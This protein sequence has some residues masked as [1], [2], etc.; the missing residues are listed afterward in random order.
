MNEVLELLL[1]L[2]EIDDRI[3]ALEDEVKH[4]PD[5]RKKLLDELETLRR[6]KEDIS[7]RLVDLRQQNRE[8]EQS[9]ALLEE[10]LK[11][12]DNKLLMIKTQK[13][14]EAINNEINA[15]RDLKNQIE[16][17]IFLIMGDI[18]EYEKELAKVEEELQKKEPE[19]KKKLEALEAR[20]S[21][22]ENKKKEF[23]DERKKLLASVPAY[24]AS[25]YERLRKKGV[26]PR[27]VP[28]VGGDSCGGCYMTL[29]PKILTWV[30]TGK[31]VQ[32]ENCMRFLYWEKEK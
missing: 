25:E 29:T 17:E 14:F 32:C 4:V 22:I 7:T 15:K 5:E 26:T 10:E 16:E 24:Y 20:L 3:A 21:E 31:I 13:E 27:V 11:E 23:D 30:K 28:V 2:Q 12:L 1:K 19:Y 18:E 6:R 8:K 9:L